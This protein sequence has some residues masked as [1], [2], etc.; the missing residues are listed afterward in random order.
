RLAG[1]LSG[2]RVISSVHNPDHEPEFWND[3]AAVSLWKRQAALAL[4]RWTAR[5]GCTRMVA[6]SDY[7][8]QSAHRRLRFPLERTELLYNP[9]DIEELQ[10]PSRRDRTELLQELGLPTDS[11]VLLNVARVSPQKGL[12]YA[13]RAL[14]TIRKC[15]PKAHLLSVGATVDAA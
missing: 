15:Y 8:G 12:I 4:D 1:R 10:S 2:T 9:V 6:V 13:I 7:V 3:G 5:F 11:L 14:P